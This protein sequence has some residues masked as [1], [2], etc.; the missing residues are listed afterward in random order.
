M[1]TLDIKMQ[2]RCDHTVIGEILLLKNDRVTLVPE[3]PIASKRSLTIERYGVPLPDSQY[4]L[5]EY[6]EGVFGKYNLIVLKSPDLYSGSLYESSYTTF[7]STCPK[8]MG[9]DFVDDI[10]ID[11]QGQIKTVT[12]S[13]SLAQQVEKFIVAS[14]NTNRY[15][16]WVGCTLRNLVGTKIRD[17]TII[18]EEIKSAIRASLNNLK[19]VQ[20]KHQS[21]NPRVSPDEVFDTI[22]T[23]DVYPDE[24]DPT[25]LN[26]Y[27]EYTSQSGNTYNYT[28][29]LDLVETRQRF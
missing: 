17:L 2:N 16:P 10:S 8:C 6:T 20:T 3:F 1:G 7:K 28:Q 4:S 9:S 21:I 25:I 11:Q 24:Q 15:Y 22:Q 5:Q 26:A 23:I 29:V 12:N 19:E 14:K 27:V 13:V 18:S